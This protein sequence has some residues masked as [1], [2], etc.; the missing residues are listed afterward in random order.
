MEM[1][2]DASCLLYW[3]PDLGRQKTAAEG[4]MGAADRL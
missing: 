3:T 4:A 2:G 1:E